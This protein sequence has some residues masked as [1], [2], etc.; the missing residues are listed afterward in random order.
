M[1]N[2]ETLTSKMH[3]CGG[4]GLTLT[5]HI[6]LSKNIHSS[7]ANGDLSTVGNGASKANI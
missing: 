2:P 1:K 6:T 7:T 4:L 3:L 5:L